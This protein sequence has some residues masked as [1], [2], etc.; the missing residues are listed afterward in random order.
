MTTFKLAPGGKTLESH[1]EGK[2]EDGSYQESAVIGF[3][4]A[5]KTLSFFERGV[6]QITSKGD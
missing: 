4:E 6:V 3:D 2:S 1:T 5:T